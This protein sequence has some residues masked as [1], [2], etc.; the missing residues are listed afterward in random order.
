MLQRQNTRP[1]SKKTIG[2]LSWANFHD[3]VKESIQSR[4]LVKFFVIFPNST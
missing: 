3:R 1:I 4:D 2:P